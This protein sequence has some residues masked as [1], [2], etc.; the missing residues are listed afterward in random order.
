MSNTLTSAKYRRSRVNRKARDPNA[1]TG[2]ES[3][4][5]LEYLIDRNGTRAYKASHPRCKSDNTA[6]VEAWR[7]L[8]KPKI[9]AFLER[10]TRARVERLRMD[11]DEAL[12][13]ISNDAR[14][15]IGDLFDEKGEL[16][17]IHKWPES[18]RRSV[19]SIRHKPWGAIDVTLNDSLKARELM[20]IAGG[21]L[22]Q[23][24]DQNLTFDPVALLAAKTPSE[25]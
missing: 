13:L 3:L 5:A 14:A 19:K 15:D 11:G 10:E 17:P 20:A 22:K 9:M 7:L 16:L 6:A 8:R 4:F 25:D 23:R 21:K 12:T 24:H 1:L 18:I 2:S